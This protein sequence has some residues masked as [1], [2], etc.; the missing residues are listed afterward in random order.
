[1]I[2]VEMFKRGR[3]VDYT[4]NAAGGD[5]QIRHGDSLAE[6]GL[7]LIRH[8]WYGTEIVLTPR[9][10]QGGTAEIHRCVH[11]SLHIIGLAA[12]AIFILIVNR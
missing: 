9:D 10:V 12:L 5:L 3:A 2:K 4:V 11:G 1:M 7:L 8:R 6:A